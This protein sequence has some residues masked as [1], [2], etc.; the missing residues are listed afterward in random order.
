MPTTTYTEEELQTMMNELAK[1]LMPAI[2]KEMQLISQLPPVL[3]RKQFMEL[4]DISHTKANELFNRA[5][6]PVT[7]QLGNPRVV[8]K[9]F[10][11]WLDEDIENR[12]IVNMPFSATS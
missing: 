12:K 11:E 8:T 9:Q 4:V 6:F 10:F 1:Q 3:T 2:K 7:R 5:D